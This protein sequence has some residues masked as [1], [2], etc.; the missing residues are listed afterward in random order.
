MT[1]NR[2]DLHRL[3]LCGGEKGGVG[4]SLVA[5]VLTE[6]CLSKHPN[7][8]AL[9][10]SDSS[11]PDVW[12]IYENKVPTG[13]LAYFSDD[14]AQ[15]T[16]ADPLINTSV[17]QPL[18]IC[19]LPA[20]VNDAIKGWF[21]D[22]NLYELTND[23]NILITYVHVCNG[24]Y[25]S[26][27]LLLRAAKDFGSYMNLAFVRNWGICDDW[28][29]VNEDKEIQAVLKKHKVPII[30]IPKFPYAERNFIEGKQMSFDEALSDK[31]LSIVSKQRI[32]N[33]LRECFAQ[34]KSSGLMD[35][36]T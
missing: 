28:T 15:R 21:I 18:T 10:E 19:N 32:K 7:G 30:D 20:Q 9:I 31:Q 5:K 36:V 26:T 3:I 33:F 35:D 23:E 12:R 6:Y 29:H 25:D 27:K 17:T 24:G 8:F 14:P 4:K 13:T 11:N 16:L 2:D 1:N 22:D 34:I